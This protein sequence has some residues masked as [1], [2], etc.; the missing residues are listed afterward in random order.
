MGTKSLNGA[1]HQFLLQNQTFPPVLTAGE[2]Q[3]DMKKQSGVVI[4]DMAK[5]S[6][7]SKMRCLF[8]AFAPTTYIFIR[9]F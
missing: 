1:V 4:S 8:L 5:S 2:C 3:T 9:K 6:H 7:L